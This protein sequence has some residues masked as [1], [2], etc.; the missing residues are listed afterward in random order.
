MKCI[1]AMVQCLR[2][3]GEIVGALDDEAYT[4]RSP[5]VMNASVGG[6]Y[7]HALD[8]FR[9][10]LESGSEATVD[11]DRRDRSTPV[12]LDRK[13]ALAET[14]RLT[15]LLAGLPD[16]WAD[17]PVVVSCLVRHGSDE[18]LE[19]NST[20]GREAVFCVMHAI[21]HYALIRVICGRLGREL[22]GVFGMAPSTVA[23]A[24]PTYHAAGR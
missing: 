9:N 3:G 12:E 18:G 21:H 22:Q 8:H 2:E 20:K 23:A 6:H 4:T 11:Y 7:R 19:V 24:H 15:D 13:A 10:L 14:R 5:E 16:D 17:Q 1:E